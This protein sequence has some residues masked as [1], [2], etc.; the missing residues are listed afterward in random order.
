MP[1]A[2]RTPH[3]S[4]HPTP[5]W[6]LPFTLHSVREVIPVGEDGYGPLRP[7]KDIHLAV[8]TGN[9]TG[10]DKQP[11]AQATASDMERGRLL[12]TCFVL[13]GG[14]SKK[15]GGSEEGWGPCDFPGKEGWRWVAEHPSTVFVIP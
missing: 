13:A 4:T 9:G 12:P 8:Q 6:L 11:R 14:E 15:G 5:P 3:A 1:K 2:I 10:P 7:N